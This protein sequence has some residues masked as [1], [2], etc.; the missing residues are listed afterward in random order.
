MLA[1]VEAHE[2]LI[3]GVLGLAS[4]YSWQRR[5]DPVDRWLALAALWICVTGI[6]SLLI[7]QLD[8]PV[9]YV[10]LALRLSGPP[11]L[12]IIC[13]E[14]VRTRTTPGNRTSS[15]AFATAV[16]LAAVIAMIYYRGGVLGGSNVQLSFL[17]P[18]VSFGI[19]AWM[20]IV[21]V[22]FLAALLTIVPSALRKINPGFAGVAALLLLF[23]EAWA[24]VDPRWSVGTIELGASIS[25]RSLLTFALA[26]VALL[27]AHQTG[28]AWLLSAA[29]VD[30]PEPDAGSRKSVKPK[31]AMGRSGQ[32]SD[33]SSSKKSAQAQEPEESEDEES[34]DDGSPERSTSKA[35]KKAVPKQKPTP[36]GPRKRKSKKKK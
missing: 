15:L 28:W 25:Y 16:W 30:P 18:E 13:E 21:S 34:D 29:A 10:R 12:L 6:V 31:R 14:S 20:A 35:P 7:A 19:T 17:G 9:R 1:P 22:S 33:A 27:K 4:L 2:A 32:S 23:S 11:L 36:R 8:D 3:A 24:A 26:A 5:R